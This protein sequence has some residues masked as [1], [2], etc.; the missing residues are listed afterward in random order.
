VGHFN[1][2][3]VDYAVSMGCQS[4]LRGLRA[5]SDFEYEFQMA[6]MNRRLNPKLDTIF[7]MPSEE[8][9]FVSSS[10]VREV[11]HFGGDVSS[12]VPVSIYKQVVEHYKK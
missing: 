12:L 5:V 4:I 9:I 7:L 8:H 10:T 6:L 2:L 3:L 1:G 11:A